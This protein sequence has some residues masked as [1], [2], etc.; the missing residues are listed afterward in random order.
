MGRFSFVL[1]L[2]QILL[3]QGSPALAEDYS[4]CRLRCETES[5]DCLNETPGPE[6]EVQAAKMAAC[7]QRLQSC[8]AECENFKPIE[9]PG[10]DNNPNVLRK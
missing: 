4:E 7:E 10:I 8:Y 2:S 3:F 6:P 5:A 1:L 9:P